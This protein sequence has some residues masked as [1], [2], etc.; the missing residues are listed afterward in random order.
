MARPELR[1]LPL[2]RFT[3][4]DV[5]RMVGAQCLDEQDRIELVDGYLVAVPEPSARAA[6][7]RHEV[8]TRLE[9]TGIGAWV[10]QKRPIVAGT[11]DRPEADVVVVTAPHAA[12]AARHPTGADVL[13]VVEI[14]DGT[15]AYKRTKA[16]AFAL[17][18]VPTL[19]I[20]DL[21]NQ[22]VEVYER[23]RGAGWATVR[24]FDE[25]D[26]VELAGVTWTV[27]SLLA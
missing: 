4:D 26:S 11:W 19:W 13:L 27:A 2:K 9:A 8:A 25:H 1:D 3:V 16:A 17:A 5:N 22:R 12:F 15:H 20:V 7:T 23:P 21:L 10:G 14:A 18:G 24:Y 6:Y